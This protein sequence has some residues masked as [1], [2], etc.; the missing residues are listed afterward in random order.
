MPTISPDPTGSTVTI[1]RASHCSCGRP[2][3]EVFGGGTWGPTGY[4]GAPCPPLD[5]CDCGKGAE[6]HDRAVCHVYGVGMA[7]PAVDPAEVDERTRTLSAVALSAIY[8]GNVDGAVDVATGLQP[9]YTTP[10][11]DLWHRRGLLV[12]VNADDPITLDEA[13]QLR[14]QL[15]DVIERA[16]QLAES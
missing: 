10:L 11:V 7:R 2:A 15:D 4:C 8:S 12:F 14:D 3:R 9:V 13:R 1:T 5:P 16:D 6:R